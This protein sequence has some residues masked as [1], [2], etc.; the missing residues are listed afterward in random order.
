MYAGRIVEKG[1]VDQVLDTP[2]HPYTD[3]LIGS[4]PSRTPR[5]ERLP[6]I[7]G[8]TPNVLNL[9]AGCAFRTRCARATLQCEADPPEFMAHAGHAHRCFQPL[10]AVTA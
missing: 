5:G 2:M 6:G 1:T 9:P 3:G 4:V 8:M 10:A 7:P